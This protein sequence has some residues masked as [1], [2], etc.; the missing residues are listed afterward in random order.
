[1]DVARRQETV[2]NYGREVFELD[3]QY[4]MAIGAHHNLIA[5]A[6]CR[7]SRESM[8][9]HFGFSLAPAEDSSSL[10]TAFVQD[11]IALFGETAWRSR[12][13]ARCSTSP[14]QVRVC[15]RPRA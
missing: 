11:E 5:G 7:L 3:T 9:G 1:M 10:V 6:G 12:S 14:P 2:G 4:R 13:A 8:A 15:S